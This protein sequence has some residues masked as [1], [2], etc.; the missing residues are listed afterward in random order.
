MYRYQG[1]HVHKLMAFALCPNS[2]VLPSTSLPDCLRLDLQKTASRITRTHTDSVE[3][4]FL[5]CVPDTCT[6]HGGRAA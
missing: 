3:I 2:T 1:Y 4:H 6:S 5:A